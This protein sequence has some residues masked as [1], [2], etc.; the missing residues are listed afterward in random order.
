[1]KRSCVVDWPL[2]SIVGVA[3]NAEEGFPTAWTDE[4]DEFTVW[5]EDLILVDYALGL[6]R[7]RSNGYAS[8]AFSRSD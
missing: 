2:G 5:A 8:N 4:T 6:I 3:E 1:M 7:F